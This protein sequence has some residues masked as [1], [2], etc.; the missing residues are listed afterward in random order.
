MNE[1]E[2][3]CKKI[4]DIVESDTSIMVRCMY[5][6]VTGTSLKMFCG[7]TLVNNERAF[8]SDTTD[9]IR[10]LKTKTDEGVLKALTTFMR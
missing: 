5:S 9:I 1:F 2:A 8:A 10:S 3:Q 7:S 4:D 6:L